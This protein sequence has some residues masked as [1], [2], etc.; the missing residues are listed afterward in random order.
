M[1][2]S[3]VNLE[4]LFAEPPEEAKHGGCAGCGSG[5]A[6]C[7]NGLEKIYPTTAVR[8]GYMRYIGEFTHAPDL[9]FTCGAKVIIQTRRGI[10]LGEQ[11]SLTC[12]GCD[13]S[14]TRDEMKAWV[15]Q[16]GDDSFVFDAGRILREATAADLAEY[17]RIQAGCQDKVR[18]C[19]QVANKHKLPMNVVDCECPFGGERIIFYFTAAERVDFRPLVKETAKEYRTRIEMRQVGARDEARLLADYETCG[20]EVCCK[21]FLKTLRPIS[22]RMA[23]LQKATLDPTQVS[24]RCGRLKCCLRYEH[25]SYE[26]LDKR[27][28]RTGVRI[29]TAH[30]EGVVVNR[31]ILT[32]LVQVKTD[33]D[34]LITVVVEDIEEVNVKPKPA[35]EQAEKAQAES[36]RSGRPGQRRGEKRAQQKSRRGERPQ[37]R[38]AQQPAK[39]DSPA[40][41][42]S[43]KPPADESDSKRMDKPRPGRRRG[44]RRR[45][46][47]KRGPGDGGA[48]GGPRDGHNP[49]GKPS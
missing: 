16:C 29:R 6:K 33:S 45:G 11:V 14:V 1:V 10:E 37:Q 44:R 20:R 47:R 25:T 43:E 36:R 31:Q 48:S 2:E 13:K 24:G 28:P 39:T 22:M 3:T 26:E 15:K 23:K 21:V 5:S 17:S 41:D 27:L 49:D 4:Q 7:G 42:S 32:Q 40:T 38:P 30:G 46:R 12:N 34:Q 19:Q 8:F 18:F 35:G 9:K